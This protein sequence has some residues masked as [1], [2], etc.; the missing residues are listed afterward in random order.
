MV[1]IYCE[2]F[3]LFV[4]IFFFIEYR[5]NKFLS[6]N[7]CITNEKVLQEYKSIVRLSMYLTILQVIA[8]FST[9]FLGTIL[10]LITT[11]YFALFISCANGVIFS[12]CRER[13]RLENKARSLPAAD[14]ELEKK[15]C[16]ISEIWRKKLLPTF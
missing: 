9:L 3:L 11:L 14:R 5:I 13:V 12:L 4:A 15:Y 6:R 8:A 1:A 2:L 16:K 7:N 10:I